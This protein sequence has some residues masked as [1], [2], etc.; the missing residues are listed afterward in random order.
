MSDFDAENGI[1]SHFFPLFYICKNEPAPQT[2]S[3]PTVRLKCTVFVKIALAKILYFFP[4]FFSKQACISRLL[5]RE[6]LY[7]VIVMYT[8]DRYIKSTRKKNK[9]EGKIDLL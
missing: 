6:M 4:V 1:R 9:N 5:E 3:D 7:Y 8:N 2:M